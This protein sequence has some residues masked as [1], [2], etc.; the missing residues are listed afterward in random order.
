MDKTT[1]KGIPYA[2]VG[3][4]K[5]NKG[6]SADEQGVFSINSSFPKLDSLR[7]SSVGYETQVLP[8]WGWI[9]GTIVE[10]KQKESLLEEVVISSNPQTQAYTL[11][12]FGRCSSN[13]YRTGLNTINQLAQL[14]DAPKAGMQLT[15]LEICKD[16]SES[17]FR[18]RIYDVG[19]T[20][21]FPTAD[22]VDTIID[23]KSSE[24]HVR[25]D[26]ENYNIVIP[27]K[28][29]FIA[30]EWLFIPFNEQREK[31]K[32]NKRKT[33]WTYYKPAL[34][35]V[36]NRNAKLG[37]IWTLRFDGKWYKKPPSSQDFN[38]QITA[39]LR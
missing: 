12:A 39:K 35:Y 31:V 15:E 6:V 27:K 38:F 1:G 2:T 28:S 24:S 29:F 18:I 19:S 33:E 4:I 16:P 23:V 21:Q 5:E 11:N 34:R 8:S 9:N 14:F 17:I 25:I 22:L 7:I 13:W 36:D 10:L 32:R 37:I 20:Y 30:I 3:L 26:L